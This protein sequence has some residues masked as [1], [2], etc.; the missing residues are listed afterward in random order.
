MGIRATRLFPSSKKAVKADLANKIALLKI[1]TK[2]I[3]AEPL[4]IYG[5]GIFWQS[6]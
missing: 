3:V 5:S 4:T 2:G 6:T 1:T